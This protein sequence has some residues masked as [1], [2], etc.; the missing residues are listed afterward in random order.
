MIY[1]LLCPLL[2]IRRIEFLEKHPLAIEN[3]F[4]DTTTAH[5]PKNAYKHDFWGPFGMVTLYGLILW[6]SSDRDVS[7]VYVVWCAGSIFA[8]L[9]S[10]VWTLSSTF[11]LHCSVIGYSVTPILFPISI[12]ILC[13]RPVRWVVFLLE[14]IAV[15]YASTAAIVS[16]NHICQ[17]NAVERT[18][19]ILLYIP[20]V[21][22]EL[23]FMALLPIDRV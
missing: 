20:I 7:W 22:V 12:L 19:A 23:Y 2:L 9:L 1:N 13:I 14:A 16:Y 18:R 17:F 6:L 15:C 11:S 3:T 21:L 8:H 5:D 4:D 10:R